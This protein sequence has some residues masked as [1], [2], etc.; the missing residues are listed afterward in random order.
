M[1]YY[2]FPSLSKIT[3]T[4]QGIEY[5]GLTLKEEEL[6]GVVERTFY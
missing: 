4:A 2:L 6:W 5:G 3:L 1:D